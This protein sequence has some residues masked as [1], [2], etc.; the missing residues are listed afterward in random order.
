MKRSIIKEY[1][2]D[3]SVRGICSKNTRYY[4]PA[5]YGW[6]INGLTLDL[7]IFILC[8]FGIWTWYLEVTEESRQHSLTGEGIDKSG[9]QPTTEELCS[10]VQSLQDLTSV[11]RLGKQLRIEDNDLAELLDKL[12]SGF[13]QV[14][15]AS[16]QILDRWSEEIDEGRQNSIMGSLMKDY[17]ITNRT[18]GNINV[19]LCH[20][21]KLE[22]RN[23]SHC[24]IYHLKLCT[25][26]FSCNFKVQIHTK[27][28]MCN[29]SSL[30]QQKYP[31]LIK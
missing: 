3:E 5:A 9:G 18:Y 12:P 8:L 30:T 20:M 1:I 19:S 29:L 25:L 16:R 22:I 10:I 28:Y 2:I 13:L 15:K 21:D 31:I 6:L 24:A 17:G 27:Y 7:E 23:F 26:Y 4:P 11:W 14:K